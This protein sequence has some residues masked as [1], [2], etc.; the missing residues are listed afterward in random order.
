MISMTSAMCSVARGSCVGGQHAERAQVA[1]IV[2]VNSRAT[3]AAVRSS[4]SALLDDL[5]VDVGDVADVS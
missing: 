4:A 1:F 3:S 2:A 5:V